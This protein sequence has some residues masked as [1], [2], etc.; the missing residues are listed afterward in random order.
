MLTSPLPQYRQRSRISAARGPRVDSLNRLPAL[1]GLR[2]GTSVDSSRYEMRA[3]FNNE[4]WWPMVACR[5]APD[6]FSDWVMPPASARDTRAVR[7]FDTGEEALA[8]LK[9]PRDIALGAQR[10]RLVAA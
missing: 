1:Y 6:S 9:T 5:V 8:F 7:A 3:A 2:M 10:T 4:I